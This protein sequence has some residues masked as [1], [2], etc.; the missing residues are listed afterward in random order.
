MHTQKNRDH[1]RQARS[2]CSQDL[3]NDASFQVVF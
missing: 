2:L 1:Y 3:T